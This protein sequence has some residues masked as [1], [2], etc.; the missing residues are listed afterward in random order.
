MTVNPTITFVLWSGKTGG[1][2]TFTAALATSLAA[3]DAEPRV[4]FVTA[5]NEVGERLTARGVS[6]SELGLRRGREVLSHSAVFASELSGVVVLPSSG[7]LAWAVRRGGF[8]GPVASV[9]HFGGVADLAN[10]PIGYRVRRSI[11]ERCFLRFV[12]AQIAV[13]DTVCRALRQRF[14]SQRLVTI[15]NAVDTRLFS[16]PVSR[17]DHR[18]ALVLGFAGRLVVGK[19]L[20]T[21]VSA[22]SQYRCALPLR[23]RVAG[24]GP[25]LDDVRSAPLAKGVEI[26]FL[27][28]VDDMADFWRSVDVAVVPSEGA[29]S[30]GMVAVEAM[31]CGAS[32]IA[33]DLPAYRE[34]VGADGCCGTFFAPGDSEALA[35]AIQDYA[36]EPSLIEHRGLAA[37]NR[38][39]EHFDISVCAERYAE[40]AGELLRTCGAR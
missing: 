3:G 21:L 37:R 14:H 39:C 20:G 6:C 13:S 22:L 28:R 24:E 18:D 7:Y 5:G 2:E 17:S 31:A 19:G 1:A 30:F 33:S 36:A 35:V 10:M 16:P 32:V 26:E 4:L 9:E 34:V 15:R 38:V 11:E 40:L 12:D 8:A 23:L 29:E 27:G 25:A